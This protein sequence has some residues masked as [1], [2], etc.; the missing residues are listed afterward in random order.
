MEIS[1]RL[2]SQLHE[3]IAGFMNHYH[4]NRHGSDYSCLFCYEELPAR[5][6]YGPG[7]DIPHREDCEG[8]QLLNDLTPLMEEEEEEPF[9]LTVRKI[10]DVD[11]IDAGWG[12]IPPWS[13]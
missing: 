12:S 4:Y 3:R 6:P 7:G 10:T 9:L 11:L 8:K 1:C 2:A 5:P 13:S